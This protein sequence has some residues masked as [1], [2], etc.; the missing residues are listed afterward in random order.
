MGWEAC[1]GQLI[2]PY[3][4]TYKQPLPKR[5]SR[6]GDRCPMQQQA[7][8]QGRLAEE[9][10]RRRQRQ[11]SSQQQTL[12]SKCTQVG[13]AVA[14]PSYMCSTLRNSSGL[15]LATALAANGSWLH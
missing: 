8:Q 6:R 13:Q 3:P 7:Q 10:R 11:A 12:Q 14:L 5:N 2:Q 1:S 15:R 4:R 9:R